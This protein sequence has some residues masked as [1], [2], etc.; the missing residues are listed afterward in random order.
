MRKEVEGIF[1]KFSKIVE[2]VNM[3]TNEMSTQT[4]EIM[5]ESVQVDQ[6]LRRGHLKSQ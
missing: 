5:E 2:K 3:R 4:G 1:A 6:M